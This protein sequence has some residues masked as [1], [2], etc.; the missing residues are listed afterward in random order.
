MTA[1]YVLG[2]LQGGILQ[3]FQQH[4][5]DVTWVSTRPH[6]TIFSVHPSWSSRELG[7][8]F[9][10]ELNVLAED[11]DRYKL[12]YRSPDKWNS[13]SPYEQTFQHNNVLIVLYNIAAGAQHAHIDGFFPK[14][15]DDRN[16]LRAEP[17]F[18]K[19]LHEMT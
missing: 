8:F 18:Q 7:M 3:P 15:L 1:D 11:V 6:N 19:M 17:R 16:L 13:S 9:P 10:E 12:V 14:T 4:T 5:W 2:S